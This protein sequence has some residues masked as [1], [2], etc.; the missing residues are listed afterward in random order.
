MGVHPCTQALAR[1]HAH[2]HLDMHVRT[3]AGV[4]HVQFE[5][6]DGTK[7]SIPASKALSEYGDVLLAYE[8]N[9]ELLPAY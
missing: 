5:G 1:M 4:E 2:I 7:A 8:M 9:G 6:E 3:Q